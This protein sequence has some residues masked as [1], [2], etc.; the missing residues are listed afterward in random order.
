MNNTSVYIMGINANTIYAKRNSK[1]GYITDKK[2]PFNKK[3]KKLGW[4]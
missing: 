1:E 3:Y 4:T 2:L